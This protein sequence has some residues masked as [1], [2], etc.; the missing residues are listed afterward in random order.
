MLCSVV[1][2]RLD[3]TTTLLHGLHHV[4]CALWCC[5]FSGS[6]PAYVFMLI[7]AM[8]DGGVAAGLPRDMAISLAAQTVSTR[9]VF[10]RPCFA[11]SAV[12]RCFFGLGCK[13]HWAVSHLAWASYC[14]SFLMLCLLSCVAVAGFWSVKDGSGDWEAPCAAQGLSGLTAR[15]V[16]NRAV[17]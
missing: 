8:A 6:G 2:V 14:R 11:T 3:S 16:F 1:V 10:P 7:E 4:A 9:E 12:L 5:C 15:C 17:R 13:G